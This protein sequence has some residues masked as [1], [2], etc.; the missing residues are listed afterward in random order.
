MAKV[1]ALKGDF[2][3]KEAEASAA[4][5]PGHL[6]EFGGAN[7][8][9]VHA[10]AGGNGRKAFALENDLIGDGIDDAYASGDTVQYGVFASGAEVNALVAA[11]ATA[12]TK[13][14]PLESNGTGTLRLHTPANTTDSDVDIKV[15]A[16]VAYALE[17]VDNSGGGAAVRIKV[18]VA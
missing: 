5:T 6:V 9:R 3:R 14:A 1:I 7:E 10:T 2:M 18:E 17:A 11:A 4:I 12:I 8:L 16:I 13:G 15:G